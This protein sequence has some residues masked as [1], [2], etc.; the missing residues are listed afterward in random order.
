MGMGTLR[1]RGR[2][3]SYPIQAHP[4]ASIC[5]RGRAGFHLL[6][7]LLCLMNGVSYR[8]GSRA[9]FQ[10]RVT[11]LAGREDCRCKKYCVF[12]L[13]GSSSA[14]NWFSVRPLGVGIVRET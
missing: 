2:Q 7:A 11:E 14:F 3:H 6:K 10:F 1:R 8:C 9:R 12:P 4:Y 5:L 13:E